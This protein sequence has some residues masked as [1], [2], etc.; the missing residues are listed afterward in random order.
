MNTVPSNFLKL[1]SKSLRKTDKNRDLVL[2]VFSEFSLKGE[3]KIF[4]RISTPAQ[5]TGFVCYRSCAMC[6]YCGLQHYTKTCEECHTEELCFRLGSLRSWIKA[7]HNSKQDLQLLGMSKHCE[8]RGWRKQVW[9][10]PIFF[11]FQY[12]GIS[13]LLLFLFL[14]HS[15]LLLLLLHDLKSRPHHMVKGAATK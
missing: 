4:L 6:C 12:H 8:G 11:Q 14:L 13:H 5:N 15:F 7:T 9:W 1:Q 2:F 3:K 10:V